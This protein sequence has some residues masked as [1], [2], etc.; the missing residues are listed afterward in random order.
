[1]GVVLVHGVPETVAVWG[2]LRDALQRDD[3]ICLS[4][5]G[6]GAPLPQDFSATVAG[7]RDWLVAE[8]EAVGEPVHLVGHDWGGGHVLNVAMTRPDL[9]RSWASDMLGLFDPEYVWHDFAQAWQTPGVGEEQIAGML[10]SGPAALAELLGSFGVTDEVA[11]E[12][13]GA[14]DE[15]MTRA[16]LSLYRSTAQPVMAEL[17]E[18]LEAAAARPGLA[19]V[20]SD[21]PFVGSDLAHRSAA[22]AG[23][24]GLELDGVGHWWMVEDPKRGAE[25]LAAFWS[26]IDG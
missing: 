16:I 4:P 3:V 24:R 9:L 2:P 5:P 18:G 21:D 6:F 8:L 20:A 25:A 15:P 26:E 11:A 1:M 13:A 12:L 22:R 7:Y 19:I 17:G 10:A 23:A 14:F